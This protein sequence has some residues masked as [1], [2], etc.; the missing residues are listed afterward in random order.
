MGG[1][2]GITELRLLGYLGIGGCVGS[3]KSA[4]AHAGKEELVIGQRAGVKA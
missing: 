2:E 1:E 3:G 4:T